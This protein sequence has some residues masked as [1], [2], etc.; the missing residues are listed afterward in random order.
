MDMDHPVHVVALVP[1]YEEA[2]RIGR[3]VGALL[4][5]DEVDEV[6]VV[7]DGSRDATAAAAAAAGATVVCLPRNGGKGGALTAGARLILSRPV[8][9]RAVLFADADLGE[10]AIHLGGLFGPV[11][12]GSCDVAVADLPPQRGAAGFGI[13]SGLARRG[14]RALTGGTFAEPLSGQR[15]VAGPALPWLVPFAAG[16]G[17]EVGMTLA[18]LDAGL[19]VEEIPLPLTHAPTGRNLAGFRHRG[20]QGRDVCTALIRAAAGRAVRTR[21]RAR[22]RPVLP[23]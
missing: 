21:F 8:S 3:T 14:L 5:L 6:I 7:D 4:T 18:A 15:A 1:A 23:R 10:S 22:P 2:G 17:A 9:P 20:R 16:F 13:T 11:L 19:R 12:A